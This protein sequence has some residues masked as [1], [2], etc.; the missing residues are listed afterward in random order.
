MIS[1]EK[2]DELVDLVLAYTQSL[3]RDTREM[4]NEERIF[5]LETLRT[6]IKA[7]EDKFRTAPPESKGG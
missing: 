4:T 2:R 3:R 6:G 5:F 7:A 1:Q